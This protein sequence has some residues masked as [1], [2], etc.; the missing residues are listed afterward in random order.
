MGIKD[1]F[2]H[3]HT[4]THTHTIF[5]ELRVVSLNAYFFCH[6]FTLKNSFER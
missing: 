3:T 5:I 6:F 2:T 4:H 1:A